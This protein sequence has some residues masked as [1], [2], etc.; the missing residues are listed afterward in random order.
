M[1]KGELE[2]VLEHWKNEPEETKGK[3]ELK[4]YQLWKTNDSI[5]TISNKIS[6]VIKL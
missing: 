4:Q 3:K 2:Q 6:K 1:Q 5:S